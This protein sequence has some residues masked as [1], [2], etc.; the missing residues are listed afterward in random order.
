MYN[1]L[2]DTKINKAKLPKP[3]KKHVD[4]RDGQGL[5]LRILA[6]GKK[7]WKLDYH[8]NGKRNLMTLGRYPDVTLKMAREVAEKAR[9]LAR[10]GIN[11]YRA[12]KEQKENKQKTID[13]D[14]RTF[15]D[16]ANEWLEKVVDTADIAEDT[17]SL[18]RRMLELHIYPEIGNESYKNLS[19]A[20]VSDILFSIY[21]KRKSDYSRRLSGMINQIG[22]WAKRRGYSETNIAEGL[23]EECRTMKIERMPRPAILEEDEIRDYLNKIDAYE[24]KGI[25]AITDAIKLIAYIPV[26]NQEL[27]CAK[28]NEFDFNENIWTIPVDR[29]KVKSSDFIVPLPK[30]IADRIKKII[31]FNGGSEY[32]FPSRDKCISPMGL[33]TRLRNMGYKSTELSIHGFRSTFSTIMHNSGLCIHEVI[34]AQLAHTTGNS[35]ARAYNRGDYLEQRRQCLEDYCYI[36]DELKI[37]KKL[38]EIVKELKRKHYEQDMK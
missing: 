24:G 13:E 8:L 27:R 6:S 7:I 2:T 21:K 36:L 5:Y 14:K 9:S 34:E 29:M 16:V 10:Q 3:P 31:D 20:K 25:K 18:K 23:N 32:L 33:T 28:V 17:K 22:K 12:G 30:K 37:G 11:P 35:V 26:R 19:Y 1:A 4:L 38:S 15:K